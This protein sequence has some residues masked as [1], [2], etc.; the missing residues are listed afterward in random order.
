MIKLQLPILRKN[1]KDELFQIQCLAEEKK[2]TVS[3][4]LDDEFIHLSFDETKLNYKNKSSKIK[5]RIASI[6]MNPNYIGFIIKDHTNNE[7]LHKEI[8]SLKSLN[9]KFNAIKSKSSDCKKVK[10]NNV[11]RNLIFEISKKLITTANHFQC[12]AFVVEDLQFK[13]NNHKFGKKFNRLVNNQW[14]RRAFI[15]NIEKRCAI[16]KIKLIRVYP[17]YSSFIGC[18]MYPD[19]V[20]SVAAAIELNRRGHTLMNYVKGNSFF[21]NVSEVRQR[22]TKK[23]MEGTISW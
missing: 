20:D 15:S 10:L 19:E 23:P 8:I 7:I 17:Q 18:M 16:D 2:L 14:L 3:V 6:D 21:S 1:Y 9:D 12:E 13:D 5:N 22:S 4:Q 11:R